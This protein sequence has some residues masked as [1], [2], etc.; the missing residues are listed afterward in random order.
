MDPLVKHFPHE[1]SLFDPKPYIQ[2][3]TVNL[4]VEAHSCGEFSQ[5]IHSISLTKIC[6]FTTVRKM[7]LK[8]KD[9]I[10]KIGERIFVKR[11]WD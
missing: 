2:S 7:K 10:L 8:S 4:I 11:Q 9:N 5:K 3:E 6:H 1:K